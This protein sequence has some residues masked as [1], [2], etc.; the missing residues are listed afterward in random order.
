MY[1]ARDTK[2]DRLVAVKVISAHL[3]GDVSNV[4]RFEREAKAIA[5]LSHPN[6]LSIFDFGVSDGSLFSVT[7]LLEGESLRDA[8][9]GQTPHAVPPSKA[10]DYALQI[11]RGLAAAHEWSH[12]RHGFSDRA[13]GARRNDTRN[14]ARDR[15][16]HGP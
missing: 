2:L 14:G 8:L 9:G 5:A 15:G 7:E 1:R 16:V 11:T 3:A 4:A 13:D 10:A 12:R 6:I